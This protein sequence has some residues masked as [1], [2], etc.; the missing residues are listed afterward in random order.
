MNPKLDSARV[1]ARAAAV[2]DLDALRT[3][4][5]AVLAQ[6]GSIRDRQTRAQ[7]TRLNRWEGQS[8][9]YR[10]WDEDATDGQAKPFNGAPD[11]RVPVVDIVTRERVALYVQALMSGEIQAQ[12]IGGLDQAESATKMSRTL[13]WLRENLLS[14]ELRHESELLAN[15]V[16][17]DDPG[18]GVLK[19]WWKSEAALELRDLTLDEVGEKL[20]E[21]QGIT[22]PQ[23]GQQPT[24]QAM[25]V[26][27]G[28]AADVGDLIFN[29]TREEEAIDLF[30]LAFPTV[31][32]KRLRKCLKQLRKNRST[33]LPLPY[34]KEN[35][36]CVAALR[37]MQDIF[38]PTDL[39]DIQKARI[40]WEREWVSEPELRA[41]VHSHNYDDGWVEEV[42]DAGPGGGEVDGFNLVSNTWARVGG[43]TVRFGDAETDKLFEIWHAYSRS[44]DE[45]GIPGVYWT[46]FSFKVEDDVG[47]HD[48]L[49][50]PDGDYPHVLFRSENIARG[51]ENVRG[52]PERAGSMQ[53]D[54]KLQR[55]CRGAHTMISTIPPVRVTQRRGGLEAVLGPMVEVPVREADDVTWMQPPQF[56]AASIEME[57][58]VW[59]DLNQYF[60][61]IMPGVTTELAQPLLQHDTDRWLGG[62]K[63]TWMKILQL[64]QVFGDPVEMQLV[65]GGPMLTYTREEIRGRFAASLTFSVRDLNIEFVI[66]RNQA[67]AAT[68]QMD[69]GGLVDHTVIVRAGLRAIDPN[70]AEQAIRDPQVV[71][72]KEIED[73]RGMINMLANGIEA[74][75][76]Q[77]GVNAK[78]RLQT[79][80]ETVQGSPILS[81]RFM[82]PQTPADEYFRK[83]VENRM[84]NL[85]FLVEQYTTNPAIGRQGTMALQ[86][87]AGVAT[88]SNN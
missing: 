57:K 73:E 11:Q 64:Q 34:V 39:D 82:Q 83:L 84:K 62:W 81:Q 79:L 80:Q 87:S 36:P 3:E 4:L 1:L 76:R 7:D 67:I 70:L 40:V 88:P 63:K 52:T 42:L 9:D 85:Q 15:Y 72:Q 60:G 49:D 43:T 77:T 31:A 28:A 38:F 32:R 17:G 74:P 66:S 8:D 6:A 25:Q 14:E 55:D 50:Y 19:V 44:A 65:A 23:D 45:Y 21:A 37:Y 54:I 35:R 12:P 13:K 2:P 71:T 86:S 26:F 33:T 47:Y 16:E 58:A 27:A 22:L 69:T 78:L 18:I 75:M 46:V 30:A 48:L 29:L 10:K 56:P 20:L 61:R 59:S 24:P 5:S 53:S 41:R 51:V 68:L